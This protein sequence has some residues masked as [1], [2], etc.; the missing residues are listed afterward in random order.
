LRYNGATYTAIQR[1]RF[2]HE[3]PAKLGSATQVCART[4]IAAGDTLTI[5]SLPGKPPTRVIGTR[6]YPRRWVVYVADSVKPS[7]RTR[8]LAAVAATR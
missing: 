1:F 8:I 4:A 7:G 3:Q 5:W 2:A 6:V